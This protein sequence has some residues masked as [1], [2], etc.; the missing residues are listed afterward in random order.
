MPD[1][2]TELESL[3]VRRHAAEDRHGRVFFTATAILQQTPDGA[4][5]VKAWIATYR[6]M[7]Q[8]RHEERQLIEH[9]RII[10]EASPGEPRSIAEA[11]AKSE[12]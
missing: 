6:E 8:L 1:T 2:L 5:C 4:E 12:H 3:R 9:G 7:E 11:A 10:G